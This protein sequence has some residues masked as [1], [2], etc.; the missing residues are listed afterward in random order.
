MEN[1]LSFTCPCCGQ[2][3]ELNLCFGSDYPLSYFS[4]PEDE[5][6]KRIELTKSLCVIDEEH[7]FHRCRLIIPIIDHDEDLIFN[8][9]TTISEE[10][11]V[12]R[13]DLWDKA[14]RI[15][16]GPYFGWLNNNIA[17][18]GNTVNIKTI[19]HENG[20]GT[21]P[22]LEVIEEGHMLAYDQANGIT[23]EKAIEKV[24]QIVADS[25]K[26]SS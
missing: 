6:E 16:Q 3:Y 20:V 1:E 9:W 18:Y 22:Y 4:V 19:A 15:N 11:F 17:T 14:E 8:I 25:H 21:I 23:L 5:R 26:S 10:N 13:N 7:F 12:L 24:K 2:V